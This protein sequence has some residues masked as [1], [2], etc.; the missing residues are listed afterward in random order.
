RFADGPT[1]RNVTSAGIVS[2]LAGVRDSSGSRDGVGDAA[3]F[4]GPMGIAVDVAGNVYV[5]DYW[6]STIR[7]VTSGGVVTSVAGLA[8]SSGSADGIGSYARF[9]NPYGITVDKNGNLY[10]ADTGNNII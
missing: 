4:S 1:I 2:T 8:G 7:K 6:N 10:I 9:G 5:A 3:R